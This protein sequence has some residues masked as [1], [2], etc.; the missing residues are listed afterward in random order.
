[1]KKYFGVLVGALLSSVSLQAMSDHTC[2]PDH[3]F[4]MGKGG[5]ATLPQRTTRADLLHKEGIDG[6][7]KDGKQLVVAIIDMGFYHKFTDSLTEKGVIH[8]AAFLENFIN[9]TDE[10]LE[11]VNLV[12]L[13]YNL[14]GNLKTSLTWEEYNAL[15]QLHNNI[16]SNSQYSSDAQ[17]EIPD[18]KLNLLGQKIKRDLNNILKEKNDL[19]QG[20]INSTPIDT[21]KIARIAHGSAVMDAIHQMAPKAQLLPIDL[22]RFNH[23]NISNNSIA[24]IMVQAIDKAIDLGADVINLSQNLQNTPEMAAVCKKAAQRGIP[25]IVAAGNDSVKGKPAY[26]RQN[27]Q[28]LFDSV[29]GKG[30]RFVGALEYGEKGQEKLTNYTQFPN[31]ETQKHFMFAA[32]NN[33]P[34]R[35]NTTNPE[36]LDGGTCWATAV[37]TGGYVLAKQVAYDRGYQISSENILDILFNTGRNVN[38]EAPVVTKSTQV[39]LDASQQAVTNRRVLP[40]IPAQTVQMQSYVIGKSMD[41]WAVK[42]AIEE[43]VR[44][45]NL[46]LKASRALPSAPRTLAVTQAVAPVMGRAFPSAPV[47]TATPQPVASIRALPVISVQ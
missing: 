42:R 33:F 41:L 36:Q 13:F 44:V 45:L 6:R 17:I 43:K 24:Y 40:T 22:F 26:L 23:K 12:P 25:I 18:N 14:M 5:K 21:Y 7:C 37:V 35:Y 10:D 30:I 8:P 16:A 11:T 46:V 27:A 15:V 29:E 32:G 2:D 4:E 28:N 19:R 38:Y 20:K 1:M 34:V 9:E 39:P 3:I 47:Q 31:E